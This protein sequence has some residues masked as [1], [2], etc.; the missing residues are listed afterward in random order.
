[1]RPT[2]SSFEPLEQRR[3][4]A[5]FLNPGN[6]LVVIGTNAPETIS[7]TTQQFAGFRQT[8]V[9]EN[10]MLTFFTNLPVNRAFVWSHGGNDD[11]SIG[12]GVP[13]AVVNGGSGDDVLR[14]GHNGDVLI[15]DSGND[16]L[17]GGDGADQ[18]IGGPGT[19]TADYAG[20]QLNIQV[21]LDNLSND[22][23]EAPNGASVEF[24]NVQ[25]DV[26]N[27]VGGN[28]HDEIFAAAAQNLPHWFVGNAGN[29][30]LDGGAS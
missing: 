2:F 27:V 11:V 20:R 5:A 16:R 21:T 1:M 17:I 6:E 22:G 12:Y 26:E 7:V 14:G 4:F 30:L 15:G 13:K 18:M 19:D 8:R 3:L 23:T 9:H 29:D 25:M 10:G 24:D 28:G